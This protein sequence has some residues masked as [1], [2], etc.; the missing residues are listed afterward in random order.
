MSTDKAISNLLFLYQSCTIIRF[1]LYFIT[2]WFWETYKI[3]KC[4]WMTRNND[5]RVDINNPECH[6]GVA[7]TNEVIVSFFLSSFSLFY[8]L[9]ILRD[10]R[11]DRFT[12]LK[13]TIISFSF[14]S[15][16]FPF[17]QTLHWGPKVWIDHMGWWSSGIYRQSKILLCDYR[18]KRFLDL[19]NREV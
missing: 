19:C 3:Q 9:F 7:K 14:H 2:F 17:F 5:Q 16:I 4:R 13:R 6:C 8:H 11:L 15:V 1:S 18:S 12:Y 10:T